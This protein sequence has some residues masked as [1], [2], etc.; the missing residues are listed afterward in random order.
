MQERWDVIDQ[1]KQ[2]KI[3]RIVTGCDVSIQDVSQE[4]KHKIEAKCQRTDIQEV[5]K[6]LRSL[7]N[8]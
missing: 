3:F 7:E 4:H 2:R 5:E 8:C 1:V 6:S